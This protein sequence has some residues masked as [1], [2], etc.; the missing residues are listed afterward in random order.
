MLKF[1]ASVLLF[2]TSLMCFGA[3]FIAGK[4]Y[5]VIKNGDPING[6]KSAASVV[7]FFSFGCHWCYQLEPALGKWVSQQGNKI[8]FEKIPVIFNKDWESYAKAYY[9]A[10]A[11]SINTKL[12]P[13]LFKAIIEEKQALNSNQSMIDFFVKN[14]V[15]LATAQSAFNHSPSIDLDIAASQRLMTQYHISAVPAFIVR[16]QYKTDLQM[17]KTEKRLFAILDFLL[18]QHK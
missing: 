9:T 5:E 1:I 4:D 16:N 14:G 13:A 18:A 17:A 12:N 2:F 7:E 6:K 15:D 8:N 10:H 3:D 11:L